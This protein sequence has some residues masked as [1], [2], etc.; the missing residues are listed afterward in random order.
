VR[1][2]T[3]KPLDVQRGEEP[4]SGMR[5]LLSTSTGECAGT[6]LRRKVCEARQSTCKFQAGAGLPDDR[7]QLLPVQ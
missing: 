7:T 5:K 3:A 6:L 1:D 2:S 4:R